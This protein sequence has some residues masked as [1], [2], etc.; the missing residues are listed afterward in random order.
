AGLATVMLLAAGSGAASALLAGLLL[1][2]RMAGF[3]PG[4]S[5][6]TIEGSEMMRVS[7]PLMA[8][9]VALFALTQSSYWI[10][11]VFLN[12]QDVALYGAAYRLMTYV[13]APLAIAGA[14]TPPMIAEMYAQGRLRELESTLRSVATVTFIP[15]LFA[16]LLFVFFGGPIMGLAFGHFYEKAALAL[17]ILS[18]GQIVN[19]WTGS[20]Q[21]VLMMAGQQDVMMVITLVTGGLMVVAAI[22]GAQRFGV[23]G[24]SIAVAAGFALQNVLMML[25]AK[26]KTGVWTHIVLPMHY[27]T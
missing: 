21:Q 6:A 20:C 26:R 25:A 5:K 18:L 8:T 23:P 15:S 19:V 11:G 3:P 22:F 4:D 1:R 7:W 13:E 14:V 17:A 24:I 27:L 16:L 12:N 2:G 10:A 9:N